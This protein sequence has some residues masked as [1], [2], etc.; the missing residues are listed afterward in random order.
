MSKTT[1]Y[2]IEFLWHR[3]ALH[4]K[5]CCS[6]VHKVDSFIGKESISYVTLRKLNGSNDGIILNADFMVVL[7]AFLQTTQ[8]ADARKCIGLVH[9]NRLEASFEGLILLEILLIFVESCGTDTAHLAPCKCG[10]Q[11]VCGIH[12]AFALACSDKRMDLIDEEDDA[13]LTL[14]HF[15][16]DTLQTLLELTFIH[17]SCNECAHIEAVELLVLQVL[18]HIATQDSVRESLYY[19]SLTRTWFTYK[20]R[21]IL[22]PSRKNLQ[23]STNLI[24]S[25]DDWVKLTCPS[26]VHEIASI[27]LQ[28][29]L[30]L[31]LIW[32][33]L[34]HNFNLLR[35]Y[36]T[37]DVHTLQSK[38]K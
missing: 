9:H 13:S 3:V 14:G 16:N 21:I 1:A 23:D 8:D 17:S 32:I 19:C 37:N 27:L 36:T 10:L 26:F 11:D 28:A 20:N 22:C 34:Y 31:L 15:L 6:F 12:R 38:T 24:V 18:G 7:V 25:A 35:L 30:F 2:L 33:I 29:L 4:T 5:L